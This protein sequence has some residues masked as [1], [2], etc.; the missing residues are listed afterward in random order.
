MYNKYQAEQVL[1]TDELKSNA[2]E[3]IVPRKP[4]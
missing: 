3:E 4:K 1:L 2:K